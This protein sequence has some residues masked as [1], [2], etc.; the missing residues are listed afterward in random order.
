MIA[1]AMAHAKPVVA[2]RVGGIPELIRDG[3]SGY[4]V[5][6]GDT[7]AMSRRVLDLLN[8]RDL[9]RRMGEAGRATVEAK[10]N[11]QKNVTQLIKAYGIASEGRG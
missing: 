11:L 4:L 7:Q 8:D 1:E 10:F 5:D 9:R 3:V 6:R 2:T